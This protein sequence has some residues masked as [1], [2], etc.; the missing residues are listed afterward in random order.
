MANWN[1]LPIWMNRLANPLCG[2]L[3]GAVLG[4]SLITRSRAMDAIAI[5]AISVAAI[6][7]AGC[8]VCLVQRRHDKRAGSGA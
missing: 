5:A 4:A 3:V 2:A 1:D 8:L 7:V 6:Y